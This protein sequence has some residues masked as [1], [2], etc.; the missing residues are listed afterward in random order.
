MSTPTPS[1]QPSTLNPQPSFRAHPTALVESHEVGDGTRIWAFCHVLPGAV[2]GR[3]CNVGDHTYIE[4]GVVIGD[5]VV[6]KNGVSVWDGVTLE[7]RV[8]VGPNAAF[9]NDLFPRAK[10]RRAEWD[11]TLVREGASIGANATLVAGT[12][13][14]RFA[15]IGAGAVVTKDVPDFAL[16]MGIPGQV[17]GYVC[18]CGQ[19]LRFSEGQAVCG[20]GLRYRQESGRVVEE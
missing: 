3:N 14:G 7:D 19:R 17:A 1:P 9:T 18:R 20:C 8:F 15:L 12:T 4:G 5:D 6:I 11:R 16:V 13:I 10:V 2:I